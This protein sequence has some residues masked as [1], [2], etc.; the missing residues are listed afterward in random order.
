MPDLRQTVVVSRR[1][2]RSHVDR[3]VSSVARMRVMFSKLDAKRLGCSWEALVGKRTRVPGPT[4]GVGTGL[5]HDIGQYVI[6]A[7]AGFDYG[8]WGCLAKGATFK[9]TGR[10]RTKPGR[11]VIAAHRAEIIESEKLAGR[12]LAEWSLG[13]RTP[14]T[15]AL[16]RAFEQWRRL[17]PGQR[18]T[19]EWPSPIG[20]IDVGAAD[21][22]RGG[23]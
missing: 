4:M 9:S 19:F 12:H 6:E 16:D 10:K 23:T 11:A 22:V 1:E 13:A 2:T 15:T 21:A 20:T 7:A 5:P 8:F 3:T 14:V 18:L 17:R